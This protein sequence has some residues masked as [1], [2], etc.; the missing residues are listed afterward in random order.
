[1]TNMNSQNSKKSKLSSLLQNWQ[2]GTLAT[3]NWLKSQGIS[4]QLSNSYVQ[5]G[6]IERIAPGIFK[7]AGDHIIWS[8][9]VHVLQKLK[10]LPV[11]VGGLSA[12]ELHGRS[13]FIRNQ[14]VITLFGDVFRLP[15]WCYKINFN[16]T[17][18]NYTKSSPWKNGFL[19]AITE[20]SKEP[21]EIQV[22]NLERAIMEFL[23]R[24]PQH[25]TYEEAACLME[26]LPSLRPDVVQ[27]LLEA[28]RSMKVKRLFLHLATA[29][30]HSWVLRLNQSNIDLGI[31]ISQIET[32]GYLDKQHLIYVPMEPLGDFYVKQEL[33]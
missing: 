13:H 25:H 5:Y 28:C 21:F 6:W 16:G 9:A 18:L 3:A 26:N 4:R 12:I 19:E 31:G 1:M 29:C 15:S 20:Y 30:Q 11:H 10:K 8:S 7:R 32:K 2:S 14:T 23:D 22:S 17:Q 33:F 27:T 24:V